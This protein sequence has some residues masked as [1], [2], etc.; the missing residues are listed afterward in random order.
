MEKLFAQIIVLVPEVS[1]LPDE[2]TAVNKSSVLVVYT[3][4]QSP[5]NVFVDLVELNDPSSRGTW[6]GL[7]SKRL[8]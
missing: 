7:L 4:M 5:A 8:L 1:L 3:W 6:N 2:T